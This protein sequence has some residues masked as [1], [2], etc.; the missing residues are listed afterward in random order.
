MSKDELV[1]CIYLQK[2]YICKVALYVILDMCALKLRSKEISI[3]RFHTLITFD[4]LV[5]K[6]KK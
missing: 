5:A 6:L 1:L 2:F 4:H 3:S